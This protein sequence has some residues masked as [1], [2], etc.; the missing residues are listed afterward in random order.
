MARRRGQDFSAELD[1]S[2]TA[3][4]DNLANQVNA[5]QQALATESEELQRSVNEIISTSAVFTVA[6]AEQEDLRQCEKAIA[7]MKSD[8]AIL[9]RSVQKLTEGLSTRQQKAAALSKELS[10]LRTQLGSSQ[11]PYQDF[12]L[13][14]GQR[15][16]RTIAGAPQQSRKGKI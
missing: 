6:D 3:L 10:I 4:F 11:G 2:S 16:A 8:Q 14:A 12:V 1:Q 13:E 9:Q 7:Q 5:S 15:A